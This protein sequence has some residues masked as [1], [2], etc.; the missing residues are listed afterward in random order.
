MAALRFLLPTNT[1]LTTL[2]E[3]VPGAPDVR[4]TLTQQGVRV[5]GPVSQTASA[6]D[7]VRTR[8]QAL[9]NK[10]LL[11]Y[12]EGRNDM[13]AVYLQASDRYLRSAP[14]VSL[15]GPVGLLLFLLMLVCIGTV[16][17][18][19]GAFA[20]KRGECLHRST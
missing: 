2:V 20:P 6:T 8:V 4:V 19:V 1:L 18:N 5:E 10:I 7:T 13:E 16:I 3:P 11:R 15:F 9:A 17:L 12:I 14:A